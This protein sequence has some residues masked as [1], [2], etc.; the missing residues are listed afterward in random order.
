MSL[1]KVKEF[2]YGIDNETLDLTILIPENSE[3]ENFRIA[4]QN[5]VTDGV[6][7]L[8]IGKEYIEGIVTFTTIFERVSTE[9]AVIDNKNYWA[10]K[11][12]NT[13]PVKVDRKDL[14]FI[15]MK[16]KE[17]IDISYIVS[18]ECG[19]DSLVTVFP[20]FDIVPLK[21]QALNSYKDFISKC[22][23]PKAFID[24]VLQ[25]KAIELAICLKEYVKASEYWKKFCKFDIPAPPKNCGCHG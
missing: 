23:I 5:D 10:Y 12:K 11:I 25:I 16:L 13:F 9:D 3:L 21:L 24:K 7:F 17:D 18:C 22:D 15:T 14:T 19:D 8:S 4:T 2:G 1:I 6:N 20:L